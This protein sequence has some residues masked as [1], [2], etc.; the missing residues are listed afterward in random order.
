MWLTSFDVGKMPTLPKPTESFAS[1]QAK[2]KVDDY[3][4]YHH[5]DIIEVSRCKCI[6]NDIS[7]TTLLSMPTSA[8]CY[9]LEASGY[10]FAGGTMNGSQSLIRKDG[11][12]FLYKHS[13]YK[14]STGKMPWWRFFI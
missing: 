6:P 5:N 13:I 1:L 11:K 2:G 7:D 9:D 4:G 14:K 12:V 10:E 8:L 3:V